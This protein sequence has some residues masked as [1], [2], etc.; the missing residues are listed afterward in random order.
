[1]KARAAMALVRREAYA[2]AV[3]ARKARGQAEWHCYHMSKCQAVEIAFFNDLW[4]LQANWEYQMR[5]FLVG[6][7]PLETAPVAVVTVFIRSLQHHMPIL[8]TFA[9]G[10]WT[11]AL[12]L[13]LNAL[14]LP[15]A[16]D[17]LVDIIGKVISSAGRRIR[18]ADMRVES[19]EHRLAVCQERLNMARD[20]KRSLA[21]LFKNS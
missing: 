16:W 19:A 11:P 4:D 9:F 14:L 6:V 8:A 12:T 1:M 5:I 10:T 17:L 13:L 21:P 18:A 20:L 7:S 3:L 15:I 2:D